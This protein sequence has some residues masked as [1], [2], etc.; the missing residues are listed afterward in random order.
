MRDR[1]DIYLRLVGLTIGSCTC[2]TKT[3]DPKL[4]KM[5]CP[6]RVIRDAMEEIEELRKIGDLAKEVIDSRDR[7]GSRCCFGA[8]GAEEWQTYHEVPEEVTERLAQALTKVV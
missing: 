8:D 5:D 4:H 3:N 7:E 2:S 1:N 6:Y